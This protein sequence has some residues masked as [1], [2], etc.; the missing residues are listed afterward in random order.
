MSCH[1]IRAWAALAAAMLS[2]AVPA[3]ERPLP[4][5]QPPGEICGDPALVG[6]QAARLGMPEAIEILG[7]AVD[8]GYP[9]WDAL[10][11][12]PWIAP[13]REQP[14]F[15]DVVSRAELGRQRAEAAFREAGGQTLLGL[16]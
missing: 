7:R 15:A 9:C 16:S 3:A 6:T 13:V 1:G 14:G 2:A 5:P 11:R 12:H 10:V 8:G 4:R